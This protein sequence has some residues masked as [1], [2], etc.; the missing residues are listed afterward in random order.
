M[1]ARMWSGAASPE[2][3]PRY[4]AHLER[5]VLPELKTIA[6]HRG[7]LVLRRSDGGT[8]RFIVITLWDSLDAIRRFAGADAET[9]VVPP[10][11]QALLTAYDRR[12][13]HFEVVHA[14]SGS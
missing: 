2:N 3:A 8:E 4:A 11:A 12:A 13:V 1:I 9:A 6:G 14:E 7:A 10:A 5:S